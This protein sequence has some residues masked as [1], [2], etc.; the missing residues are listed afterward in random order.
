VCGTAARYPA[1]VGIT[2]LPEPAEPAQPGRPGQPAR[3]ASGHASAFVTGGAY[4]LLLLLGLLEG[5]IGSFQYSRGGTGSVPLGAIGFD[6]GILVTCGLA[7]WAMEGLPGA[8]VPAIGWFV[9]SFG[10][11]MPSSAG[12]VI[13]ANTH[14]GEWFLYGGSV[15]ALAGV[16]SALIS[17]ARRPPRSSRPFWDRNRTAGRGVPP[18]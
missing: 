12:S 8:L 4:A 17:A 6:L 13:I 15:C 18:A 3:S 16:G 5:L 10:L 14:A 7:G 2:Q 1:S 11:A 9:A